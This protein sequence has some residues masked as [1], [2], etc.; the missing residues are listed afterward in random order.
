MNF[1]GVALLIGAVGLTGYL[2]YT[3]VLDIIKR[4]RENKKNKGG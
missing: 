4:V 1:L 2:A 3:L